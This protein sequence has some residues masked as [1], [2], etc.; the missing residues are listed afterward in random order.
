VI[1]GKRVA[2]VLATANGSALP[3]DEWPVTLVAEALAQAILHLIAPVNADQV[4]LVGLDRVRLLQPV[5]PGS[6]L[7]VE[8]EQRA[9]FAP[10]RR[11]D[12]CA[13]LG[14]ALAA[15]A[16]VTVAG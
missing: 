15:T 7:E 12:C 1:D 4:R 8:V 3:L 11:Y 6:R 14:G 10:L 9:A 16:E 5:R 2:L 13:H